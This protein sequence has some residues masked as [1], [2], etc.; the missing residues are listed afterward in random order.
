MG[1]GN[2]DL[3]STDDDGPWESLMRSLHG[4]AND[5]EEAPNLGRKMRV[6]IHD[7]KKGIARWFGWIASSS[8]KE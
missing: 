8:N 2:R 7:C 5:S 4:G 6:Y 1:R 3:T